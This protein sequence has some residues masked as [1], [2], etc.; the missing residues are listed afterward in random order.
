MKKSITF[1]G[2][3]NI[4]LGASLTTS[5]FGVW[6]YLNNRDNVVLTLVELLFIGA[7]IGLLFKKKIGWSLNMVASS[8]T[9][10]VIVSLTAVSLWIIKFKIQAIPARNIP[11]F[12][13]FYGLLGMGIFSL[14]R[15][16]K[17]DFTNAFQIDTKQKRFTVVMGLLVPVIWIGWSFF[18]W[19]YGK[20]FTF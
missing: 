2:I 19:R 7:G 13:L 20:S 12:I 9:V 16:S 3:T 11:A 4:L 8:L 1:L 15:T 17:S 18:I 6:R 5:P 14:I 10:S